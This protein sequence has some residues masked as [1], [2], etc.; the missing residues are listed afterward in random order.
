MLKDYYEPSAILFQVLVKRC[1]RNDNELNPRYNHN[2]HLHWPPTF[3]LLASFYQHFNSV[4]IRVENL[5]KVS[6]CVIKYATHS[7]PIGSNGISMLPISLAF[8][9]AVSI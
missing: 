1:Q 4:S 7:N 2:C 3:L 6:V 8:R 9:L 5:I